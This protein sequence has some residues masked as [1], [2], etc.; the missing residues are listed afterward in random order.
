MANVLDT[1]RSR[2][3]VKQVVFEEDLYKLLD[4]QSVTFYSGFDP[5]A[6]SLHVGH[7]VLL[8]AMAHMQRAGH[9]PISLV[10]GGTVIIGDPSGR[11]DMRQ[12]LDGD[13]ISNN[14]DRFKKQ[15]SRFIDFSEDKALMVN[16]ADWLLDLN[17]LK[18]MREI[19]VHFSVNKMLTA[20]CFKARMERGLTFFEFNYMLLQAYDFL[21]LNRTQGAILQMGGDDQWANMLAGADLIRRKERKDAFVLTIPLLTTSDGRKM[22]KT[23]AGAV[24]LDPEKTS[25]YEFYQYWRNIDDGDVEKCLKLLTFLPLSE[26]SELCEYKDERINMAKRR[27]AF[28]VC[29]IVHGREEAVKAQEAS[30][31]VF[32]AGN[33]ADMPTAQLS[34]SEIGES[35]KVVDAL[36]LAQLVKSK[37]EAR[38]LIEGGGISVNEIKIQ[39]VDQC[40]PD[41]LMQEGQFILHKGKKVHLRIILK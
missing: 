35:L 29:A 17:Y 39:S 3:F 27:L 23:Q 14:V 21:E 7:F 12:M 15:I 33:I 6:D 32:G 10:G 9:K 25:P 2:G 1:L 26:I 20:E 34:R 24:W 19:G 37:S 11:T 18:F 30:E 38:R 28:E 36:S 8:M 5:T 13:S 16:N 41:Q 31:A 40:V 4:T 22:G